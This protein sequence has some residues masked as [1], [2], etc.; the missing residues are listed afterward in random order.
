MQP[1]PKTGT[2]LNDLREGGIHDF[3]TEILPLLIITKW[4]DYS[5]FSEQEE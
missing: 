1:S 2:G 4:Y 3:S 5:L